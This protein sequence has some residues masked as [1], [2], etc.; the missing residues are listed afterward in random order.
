MFTACR[1]IAHLIVSRLTKALYVKSFSGNYTAYFTLI[2]IFIS[3][4]S[5][6]DMGG[7]FWLWRDSTGVSGTL[8]LLPI[9]ANG[10][11]E[12]EHSTG[13]SGVECCARYWS[14][15]LSMALKSGTWPLRLGGV[16]EAGFSGENAWVLSARPGGVAKQGCSSNRSRRAVS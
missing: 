4:I 2:K 11:Y 13:S 6:K 10:L 1:L 9:S 8:G 15:V 5:P 14:E 7:S 3:P 12:F 16:K